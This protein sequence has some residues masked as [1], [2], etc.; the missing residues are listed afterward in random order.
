MRISRKGMLA[1]AKIVSEVD[2]LGSGRYEVR[3]SA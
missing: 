3:V 1:A 2:T